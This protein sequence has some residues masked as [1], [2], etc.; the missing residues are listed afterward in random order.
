MR[1][2]PSRLRHCYQRCPEAFIKLTYMR[3][4]S[5]ILIAGSIVKILI[6]AQDS[7]HVLQR[8]QLDCKKSRP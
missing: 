2:P 7:A 3:L 8:I 5:S 1:N 6:E 4:A